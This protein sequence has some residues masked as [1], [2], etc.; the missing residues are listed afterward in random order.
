MSIDNINQEQRQTSDKGTGFIFGA[1]VLPIDDYTQS[2]CNRQ[3]FYKTNNLYVNKMCSCTT[4]TDLRIQKNQL[5]G[6]EERTVV[7][8]YFACF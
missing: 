4:S 8:P 6:I 7:M 1:T 2:P 3:F 5:N